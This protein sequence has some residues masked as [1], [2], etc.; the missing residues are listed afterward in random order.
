LSRI[1]TAV[2][3]AVIL[4]A[5]LVPMPTRSDPPNFD[6]VE[7]LAAYVLL[8]FL[9]FL[10]TGKKGAAV[11]LV[12]VGFCTAYGGLIEIVQPLFGRS[13]ELADWIVDFAGGFVG[14]LL[15]LPARG[16]LDRRAVAG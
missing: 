16:L 10:A 4:V 6:K 9:V 1:L 11:L 8:G 13:R 12:S 15:G 5:S 3:A 7:H 2:V 14:S